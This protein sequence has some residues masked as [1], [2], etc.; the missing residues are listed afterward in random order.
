MALNAS[1][2]SGCKKSE[3]A[4]PPQVLK[5]LLKDMDNRTGQAILSGFALIMGTSL[6]WAGIEKP[7]K[8]K[9]LAFVSELV[10]EAPQKGRKRGLVPL[11]ER[12]IRRAWDRFGSVSHLWAAH[13]LQTV[14]GQAPDLS[15]ALELSEPWLRTAMKAGVPMPPDHWRF[16]QSIAP[17]DGSL[18][19]PDGGPEAFAEAKKFL[20][21][22]A[23]KS[24]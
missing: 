17:D 20:A 4:D 13:I 16:P 21:A 23:Y 22:Y 8:N 12:S 10:T 11:D 24:R 7:S 1:S 2:K 19:L 3:K 18:F 6:F 5:L 14:E 9:M 15:G